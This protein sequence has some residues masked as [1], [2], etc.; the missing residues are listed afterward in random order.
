MT[1]ELILSGVD[2]V[3][4]GIGPGSCCTTRVQTGAGYPQL[5]AILEC[6]DAAHG[7]GG[8]ICADGGCNVPGDV[9]KAFG[10]GADFVMLGGMF[11][12]H[13]ECSGKKLIINP[14]APPSMYEYTKRFY[15]MASEEAQK[16]YNGGLK[17]YRASEGKSIN[18][19]YKGPVANTL[20]TILGGLRSA[21]TYTG[22]RRLKDLPKCTTFVRCTQ[23]ENQVFSK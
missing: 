4:V 3:K 14:E 20:Q 19:P 16:K 13:D 8:Y 6:A 9:A 23:Q 2:I 15:G 12:G 5:S 17:D 10:A 7:V 11:A 1:Q 18:V 22:S 21:C